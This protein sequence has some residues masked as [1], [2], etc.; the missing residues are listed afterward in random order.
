M[1]IELEA[2]QKKAYDDAARVAAQKKTS[3]DRFAAATA[4]A[5]AAQREANDRDAAARVAAQKKVDDDA[6][7]VAARVAEQKKA[8]DVVNAI[9][10]REAAQ[11]KQI[12]IPIV[13]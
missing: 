5:M 9:A 8:T 2:A 4:R 6:A 12:L 1:R 11:K 7:P 10:D 3:K 13:Y